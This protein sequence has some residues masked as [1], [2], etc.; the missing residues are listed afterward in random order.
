MKDE[1]WDKCDF[2]CS[3]KK[4]FHSTFIGILDKKNSE[5]FHNWRELV[6]TIFKSFLSKYC[7]AKG[8]RLCADLRY[9]E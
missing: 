4:H 5:V 2:D 3:I 8:N 9:R 6:K 7:L 1:V